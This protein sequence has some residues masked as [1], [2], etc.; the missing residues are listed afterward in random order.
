MFEIPLLPKQDGIGLGE[1]AFRF[2]DFSFECGVV[3]RTLVDIE[4]GHIIKRNL[5]KKD[6]ELDEI[7]VC[8]LPE[9]FLA[10]PEEVI[11]E[12]GD[13]VGQSVGVEIVVQ[14]V[15]AI[16]GIEADFKFPITAASSDGRCNTLQCTD[17]A[18]LLGK[19][20]LFGRPR[21]KP[22]QGCVLAD[23]TLA[24]DLAFVFNASRVRLECC[25]DP[26]KPP[27]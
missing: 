13:V 23:L 4:Q 5:M 22:S 19:R 11:Q 7:R 2:I 14:G 24:S 9:G 20:Y 21:S 16:L 26:L 1:P 6:D 18:V 8:L 12:R 25:V 27:R 3:D 10:S 17:S 15:V